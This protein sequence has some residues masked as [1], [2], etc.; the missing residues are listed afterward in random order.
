MALVVDHAIRSP[1]LCRH[2]SER[3]ECHNELLLRFMDCVPCLLSCASA[4]GARLTGIFLI[5][6]DIA[7]YRYF[8]TAE[9][10]KCRAVTDE[11]RD[12]QIHG[13]AVTTVIEARFASR[14]RRLC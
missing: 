6:A 9:T 7:L 3:S 2:E 1:A 14:G 10:C 11:R 4:A 5:G 12:A 8:E 13:R